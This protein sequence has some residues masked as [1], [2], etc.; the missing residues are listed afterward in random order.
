[1]SRRDELLALADRVEAL[2]G[3]CAETDALIRCALYARR[4]AY[5][6]QSPINGAWCVYDGTTDPSGRAR[7]FEHWPTRDAKCAA[8]T[9]S[10]DAAMSL[11]GDMFGSLIVGR[12]SEGG[13]GYACRVG[14]KDAESK[15]AANA[16][17]A[18]ALRALAAQ[19]TS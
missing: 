11:A 9:A 4:G 2:N 6:G 14:G 1:M 19:E 12:W 8:F 13:V 17:N 5:V 16:V 15:S 10:L 18:A 3:P 7:L